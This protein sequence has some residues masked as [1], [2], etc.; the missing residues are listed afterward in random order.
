LREQHDPKPDQPG[1]EPAD[2]Q[3]L[4]GAGT[5]HAWLPLRARLCLRVWTRP[6]RKPS[7]FRCCAPRTRR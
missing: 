2:G 3:P 1:R 7:Y 4:G 5:P 6:R